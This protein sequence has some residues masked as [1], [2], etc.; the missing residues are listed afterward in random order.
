MNQTTP[1]YLMTTKSF[2]YAKR[3]T[4]ASRT[5]MM[6]QSL[7]PQEMNEMKEKKQSIEPSLA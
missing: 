6:Q 3:A 1:T 5:T 2:I 4:Q 7:W